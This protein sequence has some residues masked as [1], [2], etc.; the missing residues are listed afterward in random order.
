[1]L[2]LFPDLL[3]WSWYVPFVFRLFLGVYCCYIGWVLAQKELEK[4]NNDDRIAWMGMRTLLVVV[5]L[6]FIFGVVVQALG[7]IGFA[8]AMF[9]LYLRW[10]KFP[11]ASESLQ[12][13]L[14]I[15]TVSLSLVF[16]GPGPYAFDLPL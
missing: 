10:K 5:G 16:L 2:S 4:S 7:S 14:L 15:G 1:M 9:A 12:F 3:D 13:Y 11:Q 8:L 6:S